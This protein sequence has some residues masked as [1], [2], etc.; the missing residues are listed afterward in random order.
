[1]ARIHTRR[2]GQAGSR[3]PSAPRVPEW[4]NR[5]ARWVEGMVVDLAKAGSSPSVIGQ[6]LRDQ[7][8][9]PLVKVITGKT[10]MTIIR[11]NK[12][13]RQI[14]EDMRS[15]ISRAALMKRHLEA[16]KGDFVTKRRLQ[17][18]ESKIHRLSRYY[19]SKRILPADWKYSADQAAVL[20]R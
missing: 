19:R 10:I 9:V 17:L 6:T 7:Y 11:E 4:M 15:L 13:Q 1:M 2:K 8:G 5:D 18:V 3:R 12:L 14:P 20:L 16:N